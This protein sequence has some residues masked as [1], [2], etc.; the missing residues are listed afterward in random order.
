VP[1]TVVTLYPI[2][3][4]WASLLV[5]QD[6]SLWTG[7][8]KIRQEVLYVEPVVGVACLR[9]RVGIAITNT[10]ITRGE[11]NRDSTNTENYHAGAD[12]RCIREQ[13]SPPIVAITGRDR[14][15]KYRLW[16]NTFKPL[17]S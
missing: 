2:F 4:Y 11:L 7:S 12:M 17:G 16:K 15:R 13:N 6:H 3:S 10:E 5:C 9:G 8:G 14:L 1:P